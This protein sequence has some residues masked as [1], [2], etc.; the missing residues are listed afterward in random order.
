MIIIGGTGTIGSEVT[1]QAV[2]DYERVLVVSRDDTKQ[3]RLREELGR[4][5]NLKFTVRDVSETDWYRGVPSFHYSPEGLINLAALKHVPSCEDNP[6]QAIKNNVKTVWNEASGAKHPKIFVSSDKAVNPINIYGMTKHIAEKIVLDRG[7]R[8]VRLGNITGSRGS[9][10]PLAKRQA[11][12]QGKVL[13]THTDMK[14]YFIDVETAAEVIL[15]V[16]EN[17]EDGKVHIPEAMPEKRIEPMLQEI[18]DKHGAELE[19]IGKREGEKLSE[20]LTWPEEEV[21]WV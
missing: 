3:A 21:E 20:D 14:R 2:E 16:A 8:V 17:G 15:D 9:V 19:I 6:M 1:K 11:K 10:L 13:L 5:D 7:G 12:N 4:P 18:A